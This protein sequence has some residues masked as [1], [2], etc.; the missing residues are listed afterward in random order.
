VI[1][2]SLLGSQPMIMTFFPNSAQA[3]ATFEAV[4]DLPMPPFP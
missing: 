1:D 3:A 4:L 2:E